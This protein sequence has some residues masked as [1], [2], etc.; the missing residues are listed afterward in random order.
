[1]PLSGMCRVIALYASI[2]PRRK[3]LPLPLIASARRESQTHSLNG[4]GG[5]LRNQA[6][7]NSVISW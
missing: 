2:M 1:M 5:F 4:A 6:M 3:S 7:K